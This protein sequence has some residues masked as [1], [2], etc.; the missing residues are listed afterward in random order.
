MAQLPKRSG[1]HHQ[2]TPAIIL[3]CFYIHN[4]K[5][6]ILTWREIKFN[7]PAIHIAYNIHEM[8]YIAFYHEN[9][10]N[11]E[12]VILLGFIHLPTSK[13]ELIIYDN[14]RDK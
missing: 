1:W 5:I 10:I 3:L 6:Q 13:S 7:I 11:E 14:F 12:H 4:T 8:P 2:N 9:V